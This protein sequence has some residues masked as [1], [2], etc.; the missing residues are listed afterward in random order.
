MGDEELFEASIAVVGVGGAGS[1]AVSR[2]STFKLPKL[3]LIAA[4][5]DN[6]HLQIMPEG[7]ERIL[8]GREITK[9]LGAGGDPDIALKAAELS[10][11]QLSKVIGNANLVFLCAGMGGGTGTGAAPVIARVAKENGAVVTAFV[12]YPFKLERVRLKKALTWMEKLSKE[13]DTLIII[14]N[15]KL[16]EYVPGLPIDSAFKVADEIIAR[17]IGG[18]SATILTPSLVNLDYADVRSIMENGGIGMISVGTGKGIDRVPAAIESTR[19]NKLLDIDTRGAKSVLVH[20]TGGADL[21]L[22]DANQVVEGITEGVDA[23]ANVIMGARMDPLFSDGIEALAVYTKL[24][25]KPLLAG[26][27]MDKSGEEDIYYHPPKKPVQEKSS[28]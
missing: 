9:G 18:I 24:R 25:H 4:N 15:N 17:A 28:Y 13:V 20:V 3:K 12:T 6:K 7:V 14:D 16:L 10:R 5:T 19:K 8:I 22:G 26:Q 2:I 11:A 23:H 1:N 27:A 21:A